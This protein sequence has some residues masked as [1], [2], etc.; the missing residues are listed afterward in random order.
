[1]NNESSRGKANGGIARAEKLSPEDRKGIAQKAANARWNKSDNLPLTDVK[2][3]LWGTPEKMLKIGSALVECYVLDGGMRVLSGRGMQEAIGLGGTPSSHGTKLRAF[4]ANDA[5]KPFVNNELAMAFETPMRFSR[6]GRGGVPA[7][8][9]EATLLIDLCEA[10]INAYTAGKLRKNYFSLVL[11]SQ[12]ITLSFAKA[13]IISAIDEVTGY[14]LV[15]EH[16]EIQKI[17]D[18]YLTDYAQKW[19]RL[20][21]DEFWDKLLKAKGYENYIGLPRRSF[22]GHW[23]NDVVYSRLAPG[24]LEK[25]KA[26][27]PSV[28]GKGRKY[29]HTQFLK[30][31]HGVPE[32]KDHLIKTM[33]LMDA[34]TATGQSFDILL[35]AALPKYGATMSLPLVIEND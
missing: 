6:P 22:V 1:M 8:A 35:Q 10:I 5:I 4:L 31:D 20:F 3:A 23:V 2:K 12:A 14:Q 18:K 7:I 33:T 11:Q 32:L 17:V 19:S 21:P 28:P 9:F 27:N 26:L 16:N 34:A 29:K 24:V 25:L 13:G 15:R 30:S